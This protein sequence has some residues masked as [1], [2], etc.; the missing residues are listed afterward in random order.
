MY[1]IFFL[2]FYFPRMVFE[3]SKDCEREMKNHFL[4]KS[5]LIYFMNP[6]FKIL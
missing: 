5:E 2:V 4:G 3:V 6:E 1:F